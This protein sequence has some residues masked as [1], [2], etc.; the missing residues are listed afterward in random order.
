M[1]PLVAVLAVVAIAV[2]ILV[3][4]LPFK[5]VIVYEY[6]K[7]LKYKKGRYAV[8]LDPGQY[9]V[10]S[11]S[12]LVV[13]VDIRPEFITIQGQDLLSADGVTVK[14]SLAAEFQVVDANLAVNKTA[15]FR[16][17]LYLILQLA[18]REIVAKEKIDALLENRTGI[19]GKLME[20][21][22]DKALAM[23]L[24]L[25]S[26]DVKDMMFAGEMKK[27]FAQVVKAQKEGQAALERARGETAALRN[28]ANAAR[29]MDD[30][31][32]LLQLR[33]LQALADSS[34]NTLVLGLPNNTLPLGKRS[35]QSPVPHPKEPEQQD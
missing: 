19:G 23:G 28:L 3:K 31:P 26:A 14:I 6:Q 18:L 17:N 4:L 29:T 7:A 1:L 30:N 34:G 16:G 27:A 10:S 24:N 13:P 25:I 5:R 21:T 20:M 9:W 35:E 8:T 12:T 15:N 33:A 11:L 22:K 2:L 32:N